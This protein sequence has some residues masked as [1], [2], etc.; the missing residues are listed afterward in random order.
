MTELLLS[1]TDD[2]VDTMYGLSVFLKVLLSLAKKTFSHNFAALTR[3][4]YFSIQ[5]SRNL[6]H[7]YMLHEDTK[8][9]LSCSWL[10]QCA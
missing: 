6:H 2:K 8:N 9:F 1:K 5:K 7:V 10:C 4:G 3:F